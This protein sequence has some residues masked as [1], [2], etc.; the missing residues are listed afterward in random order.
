MILSLRPWRLPDMP[1]AAKQKLRKDY[2]IMK[3]ILTI[4]LCAVLL[5]AMCASLS[6]CK[7]TD[8]DPTDSNATNPIDFGKKYILDEDNYE[9][10]YYVF[11]SD[12]TGVYECK[13]VYKSE[14]DTI[15]DHTLSG[16]VEFVWRE[17]SDGAVYLFKVETHYNEDHTEGETIGV[18]GH[19]IYFSDDFFTYSYYSPYSGSSTMRYIKEGS[20]LDKILKDK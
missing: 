16:K 7:P 15:Q 12:Y 11:Y 3:K 5:F 17:A 20:E 9:Y 14:Y 6:S 19:P 10:N 4:I 1:Q 2:R 13:Y 8:T 18:L